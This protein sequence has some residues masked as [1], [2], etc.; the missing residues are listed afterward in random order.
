MELSQDKWKESDERDI[1]ARTQNVESR[2]KDSP[3]I[4]EL[5]VEEELKKKK[6][7]SH[8]LES[9]SSL[10]KTPSSLPVP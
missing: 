6:K 2:S 9:S 8:M 3:E 7:L 5:G 10:H 4:K 1:L